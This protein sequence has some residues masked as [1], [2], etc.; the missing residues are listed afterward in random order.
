MFHYVYEIT[1]NIN[2]RKY[3]GKHST[4][5]LNDNYMGS[6]KALLKAINKYGVENFS[7]NIIVVCESEKEAY[8]EEQRLI[9]ERNAV[10]SNLY[11]N[12][13]D[14]GQGISSS[15]MINRWKDKDYREFHRL[16]LVRMWQDEDYRKSQSLRMKDIS[17]NL[18]ENE[19]HRKLISEKMI[20]YCSN[21][22]VKKERSIRVKGENNP[23]YGT[24]HTDKEKENLSKISKK[25]WE[26]EVYRNKTTEAIRK[27]TNTKEHKEKMSK[28]NSGVGN[29][30]YGKTHSDSTKLKISN[31]NK[32]KRMGKNNPNSK[33]ILLVN[34]NEIFY[35]MADA[36]RK[37]NIK[38][39]DIGK[40][41]RGTRKSAGKINGEKAIW[42]YID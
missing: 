1:N 38:H 37:Y 18:W 7:K 11:Y 10:E 3:I 25:L 32:G 29:P 21:E 28:I 5:N 34:T 35:S 8:L 14:G 23:M 22:E 42:K 33:K 40:C 12:I 30:M 31:S 16:K 2:G 41:C 20:K 6:G 24:K 15:Y 13:V 36:E 26:N 19:N 27:A 9:K 4:N 17:R 39:Q